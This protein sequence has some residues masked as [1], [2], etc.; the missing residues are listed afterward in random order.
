MSRYEWLGEGFSVTVKLPT[1]ITGRHRRRKWLEENVLKHDPTAIESAQRVQEIIDRT[2]GRRRVVPLSNGGADRLAAAP[3]GLPWPLEF[4]LSVHGLA[5]TVAKEKCCNIHQ[6]R[7]SIRQLGRIRL[8]Q[9][10]H[11]ILSALADGNY[12]PS[13]IARAFGLSKAALTRF[14]GPRWARSKAG[15]IPDL[16]R[17]LAFVLAHDPSLVEAAIAAGVWARVDR[18]VN[19]ME[20]GFR[21]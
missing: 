7:D 8:G 18:I 16:F 4:G 9:L 12:K 1:W 14:A 15:S 13:E 20:G 10:V 3:A 5:A 2:V 17:N 19:G 11:R 21:S 6:Q